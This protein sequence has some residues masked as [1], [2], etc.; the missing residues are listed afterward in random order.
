M[1]EHEDNAAKIIR[2]LHHV[3][4][5]DRPGRIRREVR[6]IGEHLQELAPYQDKIAPPV[7]QELADA[8]DAISARALRFAAIFRGES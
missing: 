8:L 3:L 1:N 4:N 7:S 5:P 2:D 6:E